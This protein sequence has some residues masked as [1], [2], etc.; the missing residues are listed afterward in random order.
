MGPGARLVPARR[1]MKLISDP[2]VLSRLIKKAKANSQ[3]IALVPTMGALHKGH[4]SLVKKAKAR[5][6]LVVVSIF[7]NPTQFGP[8]ED[9][10]KYPRNLK[11]DLKTLRPFKPL[12]VFNPQV[13]DMYPQGFETSVEVGP[14]SRI[15]C[16]RARPKHFKG[17]ATVVSKLFNIVQPDLAFFGEKDYQQL[18]II[19]KLVSDLNYPIEIV[20]CPIVREH[21]GLALSSRNAYLNKKERRSA[22]ILYRSLRHAR[23]LAQLKKDPRRIKINLL[24][25]IQLHE[26]G[27]KVDYLEILDPYDLSPKKDLKGQALAVMAVYV[28]KTRLIDNLMIK[29]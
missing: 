22:A 10:K 4:L 1:K 15:L 28:G 6:D 7:V 16:G 20:P 27:V 3:I 21:D 23:Q 17:V 13:K 14:L 25:Y 24:D 18:V 19:K 26:P 11:Q 29:A 5:A 9:L 2:K 12:L 8:G